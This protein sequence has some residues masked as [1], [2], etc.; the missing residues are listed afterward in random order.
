MYDKIEGKVLVVDY[1]TIHFDDKVIVGLLHNYFIRE[2]DIRQ[3]IIHDNVVDNAKVIFC[4]TERDGWFKTVFDLTDAEIEE[5]I[6][7]HHDAMIDKGKNFT[8]L[9]Y[10]TMNLLGDYE[11]MESKEFDIPLL[12]SQLSEKINRY[13][14]IVVDSIEVMHSLCKKDDID[15]SL[16]LFIIPDYQYNL[17]YYKKHELE[18]LDLC[19][20]KNFGF[21][22]SEIKFDK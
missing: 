1:N 22:L 12:V 8:T 13:S 16:K 15:L 17:T 11:I 6:N 14:V 10:D 21:K 18:I 5:V 3:D 20:K 19:E 9:L 2:K 4:R 7:A